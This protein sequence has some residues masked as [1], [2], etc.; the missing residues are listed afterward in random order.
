MRM[1]P[2]P[3]HAHNEVHSNVSG[4]VVQAGLIAGDVNLH[5]APAS[6]ILPRQLPLANRWFTGRAREIDAL[7]SALDAG[8]GVAV[9][10]AGGTG[11]TSLVLHW[12]HRNLERFPD[13]Q[14]FVELGGRPVAECLRVLL[15]SLE[16]SSAAPL[17][18]DAQVG[19]YRSLVAG[20]RMLIVLD[21]ASDSAQVQPLLPGSSANTVLVT[22]R[23]RLD[24]LYSSA[25]LHRV[26]LGALTRSDASDLISRRIGA[27]R[28][29]REP[30]ALTE[31]ID[32]CG[33]LPLALSVVAGRLVVH[34]S[35][36]LA[37]VAA[38]LREVSTKIDELD[39]GDPSTTLAAVLTS[40]Y[41]SLS[42]EAVE[43]L[44]LIA[45]TPLPDFGLRALTAV[46]DAPPGEVR[47]RLRE[48]EQASLA[49]QH[50]PGRWQV[51]E[52]VR[53][54]AARQAR[55]DDNATRRLLDHYLHTALA[56]DHRLDRNRVPLETGVPAPGSRPTG[57]DD[58]ATALAWFDDEHR[59]LIAAQRIAVERGLHDVVW[60]LSWAL[61]SYRWRR[62][63]NH[64]QAQGWQLALEAAEQLGNARWTAIA[65]RLLGAAR[66]RT[67]DLGEAFGH[68]GRALAMFIEQGD[69]T[70]QGHT[71]RTLA[72]AHEQV[73]DY[74]QALGNAEAALA[75]YREVGH[76]NW[77]ADALDLASWCEAKLG[78]FDDAYQHGIQS[79]RLYRRLDDH[80]GVATAL[81]SLGYI[82]HRSGR[83]TEAISHYEQALT[84]LQDR[85]TYHEANALSRL[86]DLHI[87]LGHIARARATG[88]RALDLFRTQCRA[89]DADRVQRQLDNLDDR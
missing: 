67:G 60:Q 17:S 56:C 26:Q 29:M 1:S 9:V 37:A 52:F 73:A 69:T 18:F 62:A 66:S 46:L 44:R 39:T 22:S 14:L 81:D 45:A 15:D 47:R 24:G 65:H 36:P 64:D 11:K 12:S 2:G 78:R 35:F 16:T 6:S 51:H 40:S 43:A 86:T 75:L 19:R 42:P 7:T 87:E 72:R 70:E 89:A 53:L 63:R 55:S 3:D 88:Q 71:H 28:A 54:H 33:G 80:D 13:G 58:F 85:N 83:R 4:A 21:N 48:L 82:A 30:A 23:D 27:T 8:T 5:S 50:Q 59:C 41:E 68:L 84:L 77:E 79:L 34:P 49:D 76:A 10:G 31:L 25:G 38:E 57:F 74:E 20:R 32:R 61:H